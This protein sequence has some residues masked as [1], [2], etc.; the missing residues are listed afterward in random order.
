MAITVRI[1]RLQDADDFGRVHTESWQAA[2]RGLMPDD[3]LDNISAEERANGIRA[4]IER[5]PEPEEGRRLVAELDGE[6]VGIALL[7][8]E[9]SGEPDTGEVILLYLVPEAWGRGVGPA[10]MGRCI[11]E[12]RSI[13]YREAVLWVAEANPRARRFYEREGWVPDGGRKVEDLGGSGDIAEVRYR[14]PL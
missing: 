2:Y 12:M 5:N 11:D 8:A 10:L 13:G 7:W 1:A 6:V 9:R 3:F 4:A 14:R